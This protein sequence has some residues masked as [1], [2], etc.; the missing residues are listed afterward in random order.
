M[1]VTGINDGKL[2]GA[3]KSSSLQTD[4]LGLGFITGIFSKAREKAVGKFNPHGPYTEQ[5]SSFFFPD[6]H[7]PFSLALVLISAFGGYEM[8][9][10]L[11][12]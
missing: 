2:S 3:K 5:A 11:K 10:E 1:R 4:H 9:A 12:M 8:G 7:L 6:T